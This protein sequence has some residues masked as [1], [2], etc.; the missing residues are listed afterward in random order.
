MIIRKIILILYHQTI[1][2]HHINPAVTAFIV[3]FMFIITVPSLA[4]WCHLLLALY[5]LW[6]ILLNTFISFCF[7]FILFNTFP[8]LSTHN[9]ISRRQRL[10][11]GWIAISETRQ[12]DA[13]NVPRRDAEPFIALK[14][15]HTYYPVH[16]F[17]KKMIQ[18][19]SRIH[20]GKTG[21]KRLFLKTARIHI[22]SRITLQE[23]LLQQV[24]LQ[25]S[26]LQQVALQEVI[27]F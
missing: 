8:F 23:S 19:T 25:E 16:L 7:Y 12:P 3:Y 6:N 4:F 13:I 26:S 9:A 20:S 21:F 1:L 17:C 10:L 2:Y 15:T 27:L 24:E 11:E 18:L 22:A 5:S 14:G